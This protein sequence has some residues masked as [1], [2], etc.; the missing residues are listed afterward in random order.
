MPAQI[1]IGVRLVRA[2]LNPPWDL[3]LVFFLALVTLEAVIGNADRFVAASYSGAGAPGF[4]TGIFAAAA[5]HLGL[6]VAS[7]SIRDKSPGPKLLVLR[8]FGSAKAPALIFDQLA[9]AWSRY[10][11]YMTIDDPAFARHRY[12]VFQFATLATVFVGAMCV[13]SSGWLAL[14][15]LSLVAARDWFDLLRRGPAADG[16]ATDRRIAR[17]LAHP[18]RLDGRHADLRMAAYMDVWKVVV[19]RFVAVA[20]VVLFD[21]RAYRDANQGSAWEVGYL[22]DS[23]PIE[24]VVFVTSET[25]GA[26]EAMLERAGRTAWARSPNATGMPQAI[27]IVRMSSDPGASARALL[28]RL[29]HAAR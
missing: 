3:V 9:G 22:F 6:V 26:V 5:L 21:L 20:D 27:R 11:T 28:D 8:V 12:R 15:F 14:G 24:R 10:G 4:L 23:Y 1:A 13:A 25:D 18:W 29:L 17:V 2:G 7:W 16:A 19:G